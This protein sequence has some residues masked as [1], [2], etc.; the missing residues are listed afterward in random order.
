MKCP[1]CQSVHLKVVDKRDS[2]LATR[3]RREC[4]DCGKRFTTY[5]RIED[6]PLTIIKKDG[7]RRPFDDM[8]LRAGIL[9]A[10]EKR[11]VSLEKIDEIVQNIGS[12]LR[13][14]KDVEI[15]SKK[16]GEEVMKQLKKVDKVAYI[17]FASVYR[18]FTD[19]EDFKDMLK[20]L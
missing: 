7:T 8:K 11:E 16:V 4:L 14:M 19:I 15:P 18:E 12:K 5:E 10:C 17:R 13:N 6:I 2:D 1:F 3:R 20:K 9:K